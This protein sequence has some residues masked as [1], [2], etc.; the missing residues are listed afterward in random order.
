ME[1]LTTARALKFALNGDLPPYTPIP[2]AVQHIIDPAFVPGLGVLYEDERGVRCPV[3]DCGVFKQH[4]EQHLNRVHANIGGAERVAAALSIPRTARLASMRLSETRRAIAKRTNSGAR[5][6]AAGHGFSHGTKPSRTRVRDQ[7]RQ[8][9]RT[10]YSMQYRNELDWCDAQLTT[11]LMV[12]RDA[13][14]RT[15]TIGDA[16]TLWGERAHSYI[17]AITKHYGS[18]NNAL[19][20]LNL[21]LNRHGRLTLDDALTALR[22]W[23]DAHG[24]LPT[25]QESNS[26]SRAPR[27]PTYVAIRNAFGG[28][29]WDEAMRR[30][31][32]LLDI[33]GG[34]YG[35]ATKE[36]AA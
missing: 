14:G 31:A 10:K 6:R 27:I 18:W 3:R 34:R 13:I 5:L 29:T 12:L 11:K 21:A 4:L 22:T 36:P 8:R 24:D 35:L 15:P 30:A 33:H 25:S 17:Y 16:E 23:Y 26:P 20:F 19:S 1:L 32:A 7:I 9:Q 2:V 28:V